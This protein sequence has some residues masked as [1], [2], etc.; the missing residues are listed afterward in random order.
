MCGDSE[1]GE[2]P[3]RVT[4]VDWKR[5]VKCLRTQNA[6]STIEEC[7]SLGFSALH[8]GCKLCNVVCPSCGVAL[9]EG[10][11]PWPNSTVHTCKCC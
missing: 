2:Y 1:V 8:A 4:R 5:A 7:V 10:P 11:D 3:C 6:W 9:L